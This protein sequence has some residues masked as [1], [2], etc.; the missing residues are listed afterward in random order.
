MNVQGQQPTTLTY[1]ERSLLET[2]IEKK[3]KQIKPTIESTGI[4]Y[5]ELEDYMIKNELDWE[6]IREMLSSLENKKY[7]I[8]R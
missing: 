3:L 8:D 2:I 4:I 6:H 7:L 1:D 5:D